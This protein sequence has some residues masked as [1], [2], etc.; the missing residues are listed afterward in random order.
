MSASVGLVLLVTGLFAL[1]M[2]LFLL[3]A[4]RSRQFEDIE[5]V[6]YRMLDLEED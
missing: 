2:G 5:G 6:K 3:W 4:Y 1:V